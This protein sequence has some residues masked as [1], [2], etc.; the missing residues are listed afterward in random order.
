MAIA[1]LNSILDLPLAITKP[2]VHL[3]K[4]GLDGILIWASRPPITVSGR[5]TPCIAPPL[6]LS[7]GLPAKGQESLSCIFDP[8]W[9][10]LLRKAAP[11]L[12][13]Q[14]RRAKGEQIRDY[15]VEYVRHIARGQTLIQVL[16]VKKLAD[17]QWAVAPFSKDITDAATHCFDRD[18]GLP[19]VAKAL[20][21]LLQAVFQVKFLRGLLC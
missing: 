12:P 9:P 20:N 8:P 7:R 21:I 11:A 19:V 13:G 2:F 17:A 10:W 16:R 15:K 1:T 4:A 18:T 3:A 14:E 6:G 5:T